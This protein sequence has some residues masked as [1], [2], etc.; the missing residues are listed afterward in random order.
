MQEAIQML[1]VT[2]VVVHQGEVGVPLQELPKVEFRVT[3]LGKVVAVSSSNLEQG[4]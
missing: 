4:E 3:P 2:A 1:G